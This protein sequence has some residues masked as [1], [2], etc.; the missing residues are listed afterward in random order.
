MA[1]PRLGDDEVHFVQVL[2]VILA[3]RDSRAVYSHGGMWVWHREVVSGD[4]HL[5]LVL[6]L[7]GKE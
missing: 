6:P 2:V 5:R 7:S 4:K 1:L 3:P